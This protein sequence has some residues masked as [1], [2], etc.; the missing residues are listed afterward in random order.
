[1]SAVYAGGVPVAEV[2]R[3]GFVESRHRGSVVVLDPAGRVVVA[4][5]DAHGLIFPRSSNKPMQAVAMLRAGLDLPDPA[6][7][8]LITASHS[9]EPRHVER[10]RS[11]L[12]RGGLSESDLRCPPDLPLSEAARHL[13]LRRGGRAARVLMNCSGKHTGMLLTC[14][15]NGWSTE[16]YLR[17]DHPVQ[18]AC[19]R[20]I[21]ELAGEPV[22]TVG[23][24]G[25]GAPVAAISLT[26]LARAYL[27]CVQAKPGEPARRVADAMRGEP[28]LVSGTGREDALMMRAVAGLLTKTGAE[29]VFAVAA[30]TL[31]AIALKVDDGAMRAA[32][33]VLAATL[34]RIGVLAPTGSEADEVLTGFAQTPVLG[35]GSPVGSVRATASFLDAL[36]VDRSE[37]AHASSS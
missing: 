25:C 2:V 14:V 11:L 26:G 35:G 16:D 15:A 8:A 31:G 24:D 21:A 6:D 34:R 29:G 3:S 20:A 19:A 32:R 17:P 5:G 27:R 7:L 4:Q 33:P 22:A 12:R 37:P 13:V 18:A 10:V 36:A 23:V 9:G 28:E 30:P 1:V